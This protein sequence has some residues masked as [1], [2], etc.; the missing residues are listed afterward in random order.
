MLTGALVR[1]P[2]FSSTHLLPESKRDGPLPLSLFLFSSGIHLREADAQK[3][4]RGSLKTLVSPTKKVSDFKYSHT[5]QY[6][7][8]RTVHHIRARELGREGW[9]RIGERQ[10]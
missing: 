1:V 9:K 8:A 2:V 3:G 7:I 5:S 6:E 4:K 10:F